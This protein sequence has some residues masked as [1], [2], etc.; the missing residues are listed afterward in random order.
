MKNTVVQ[1]VLCISLIIVG[2]FYLFRFVYVDTLIPTR[3]LPDQLLQM[4]GY[5]IEGSYFKQI[6]DDPSFVLSGDFF[7]TDSLVLNFADGVK[8]NIDVQIYYAEEGQGFSEEN[9]VSSVIIEGAATHTIDLQNQDYVALRFDI[10]GN[11]NLSNILI[12]N[13]QPEISFLRLLLWISVL[14]VII[15]LFWRCKFQIIDCYHIFTKKIYR[16][17]ERIKFKIENFFL[18]T[19]IIMGCLFAVLLPPGQVPDEPAHYEMMVME[20]GIPSHYYDEIYKSFGDLDFINV[21]KNPQR[22]QSVEQLNEYS[23]QKFSGGGEWQGIS[24]Q[25]IRHLPMG[26]GMILGIIFNCPIIYC[27]LLSEVFGVLFYALIGHMALKIMP[28]KKELLCAIMLLPMTLQQCSSVNYDAVLLPLCFLLLAIILNDIYIKEQVGW[29]EVSIIGVVAFCIVIIKVPYVLMLLLV[30]LIPKDKYNLSIARKIDVISFVNRFKWII[31]I[32]VTILIAFVVYHIRDSF[33]VKLILSCIMDLKHFAV[34]MVSTIK[35]L[36]EFYVESLIAYFG[37]FSVK[38]P[39]MMYLMVVFVMFLCSQGKLEKQEQIVIKRKDR[40]IYLVVS[41]VIFILIMTIL[42]SHTFRLG[43]YNIDVPLEGIRACLEKVSIIQ[44][45]QGRYYIPIVLL[46]F[47]SLHGIFPLK[48]K[49]L[50][51]VQVLYYPILFCWCIQI[52]LGRYWV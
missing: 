31:L 42:I 26:I 43:E 34:I 22:K 32:N 15:L 4:T 39:T 45:V 51:L 25:C 36:G 16:Q 12:N 11:F 3:Y 27:L 41:T 28:F 47:L 52:L 23:T 8:E 48:K 10:N 44:G 24:I 19:A 30:L 1:I 46:L 20:F 49:D 40:V 29:K 14:L 6:S 18:V 7:K 37:W 13:I 21:M 50:L 33:Y 35:G 9:S 2:A 17:A 5:Q 38:A